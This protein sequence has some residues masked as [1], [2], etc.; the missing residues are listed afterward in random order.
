MAV[1]PAYVVEHNIR[2]LKLE[3][4]AV[5]GLKFGSMRPLEREMSLATLQKKKPF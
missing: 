5:F 3:S 2:D 4:S 1:E